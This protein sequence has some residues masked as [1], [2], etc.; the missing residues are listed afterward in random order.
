MSPRT[1]ECVALVNS[2]PGITRAEVA[3]A[4]GCA[5]R[6]AGVHLQVAKAAG[7]VESD[8][9][10]RYAGWHPV[11]VSMAAVQEDRPPVS[12]VWACAS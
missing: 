3:L 4:M 9:L 6:T 5:V 1:A 11:S 7:R 10:G 2:R 12:S 8:S